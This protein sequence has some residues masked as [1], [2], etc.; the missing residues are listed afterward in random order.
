VVFGVDVLLLLASFSFSSTMP[1]AEP[2]RPA[3]A[4]GAAAFLDLVCFAGVVV[5]RLGPG[6]DGLVAMMAHSFSRIDWTFSTVAL[7]GA[8]VAVRCGN[9]SWLQSMIIVVIFNS[10]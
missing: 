5:A 4:V 9:G 8:E 2:A 10:A 3:S 6:E 1:P 7:Q